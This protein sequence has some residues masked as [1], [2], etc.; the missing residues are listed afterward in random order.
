M[1]KKVL[2]VVLAIVMAVCLLSANSFAGSYAGTISSDTECSDARIDLGYSMIISE[3]VT[4]KATYTGNETCEIVLNN[5]TLTNYGTIYAADSHAFFANG[6]FYNYGICNIGTFR[7]VTVYDLTLKSIA[8]SK[9]TLSNFSA[10]TKEYAVTVSSD[11]ID[12]TPT[13]NNN[14]GNVSVTVNGTA[15]S[16]GSATTVS[17]DYGV[18]EIKIV[19]TANDGNSSS[20][21]YTLQV[22]REMQ[23]SLGT[24]VIENDVPASCTTAGSYDEVIYCT[25]CG[26][27]VSRDT[28][29]V[30]ATGHDYD[31]GVVTQEATCT[32]TGEITYTCSVCNETY[33]EAIPATGI[34]TA[35]ETV[36]ENNVPA[37][38]TEDGSYDEVVY[39]SVCGEKLS[40]ETITVSATGHTYESVVTAPTC[41]EGGYTTYT[42]SV[43]G[44][45]YT[46]DETEAT[47]H[48]YEFQGFTWSG[49]LKSAT[50]TFKCSACDDTQ[51]VDATVTSRN[52]L[53]VVTRVATVEF[54]GVAYTSDTVTT[55][56]SLLII[57][58]LT[59]TESGE[60]DSEEV[61][62]EEVEITEPIEDTNTESE[63]DEET[64]VEENPTTGIAVA[65][66][67]MVI[68]IATA[69]A[70]KQKLA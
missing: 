2:S 25:T 20:N 33:T 45:T 19:L 68:A 39:C 62:S 18:N 36:V 3:G 40:S 43:C 35:G 8:L 11:T 59:Q 42:C 37:T 54:G 46:A 70:S 44:D 58:A 55:G 67:P 38:C 60:V 10:T 50:A 24:A 21:T 61:D 26:D 66:L 64:P 12:I 41:T 69:V 23:H 56:T 1:K 63:P 47:G 4:F 14:N 28:I 48:S 22:N 16:S 32:E 31:E 51:T 49:D 5:Y 9:G 65:L 53:G 13:L 52:V 17:L 57:G 7:S 29:T 30:P 27:E 34:H 6:T 15:V